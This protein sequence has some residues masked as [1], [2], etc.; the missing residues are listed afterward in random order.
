[1]TCTG[2]TLG[3]MPQ[4]MAQEPA[5]NDLDIEFL[6]TLD[7]EVAETPQGFEQVT[8]KS[9]VYTPCSEGHVLRQVL[10]GKPAILLGKSVDWYARESRDMQPVRAEEE[11]M[12]AN[13]QD[14]DNRRDKHDLRDEND[15]FKTYRRGSNAVRLPDFAY[16]DRHPF[17]DEYLY[18][19][20]QFDNA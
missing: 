18:W 8:Q 20:L 10:E 19:K 5:Y 2:E 13:G 6:R 7:V 11:L 16:R 3:Q 14:R 15:I 4:A 1:M 17:R 12:Q 9:L